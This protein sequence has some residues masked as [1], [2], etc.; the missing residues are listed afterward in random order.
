M[1]TV[2][3][4]ER[5]SCAGK[6][7]EGFGAGR[8]SGQRGG[9]W[10]MLLKDEINV[11]TAA[12]ASETRIWS[13]R[14]RSKI[15]AIEMSY[16]RS[17]F[18]VRWMEGEINESVYNR[19]GMLGE[20]VGVEWVRRNSLRSFRGMGRVAKWHDSKM[21]MWV[22][23]YQRREKSEDV[24]G[25]QART[26]ISGGSCDVGAPWGKVFRTRV[27]LIDDDYRLIQES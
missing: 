12:Y 6:W 20:E 8:V 3:V 18:G 15:K 16:L 25:A 21:F 13:E 17:A 9:C 22:C 23:W 2:K 24:Q 27:R 4:C 7:L 10:K 11:P 14:Q 1:E 26:N 5:K 19:F